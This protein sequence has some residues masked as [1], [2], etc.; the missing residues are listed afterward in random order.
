MQPTLTPQQERAVR[1]ELEERAD[2][3]TDEEI[4]GGT[5]TNDFF[6]DVQEKLLG[7]GTK[8]VVGPRGC[9]K[10]HMMRFA[11]LSCLE[12]RDRPFAIYV[13]FNRYYRL[14]PMLQLRTN[15]IR[16]F[17][18]WAL[19]NTV[20]AA[21]AAL[22]LFKA[23]VSEADDKNIGAASVDSL[24]ALVARLE[25]AAPLDEPM[26][27][28]SSKLTVR[29]VA[30][31]IE[32]VT[33]LAGRR[34]CV[35]LLDDAALTL[36]PDYLIEFFDIVRTIKT[37]AISPKA[38]IYPGTTE[39]GPRFHAHHEAEEVPVWLSP[40]NPGY[41][42][43]MREIAKKRFARLGDVS[44]DLAD[45]IQYAAFGIPRAYLAMLRRFVELSEGSTQQ[46]L[47]ATIDEHVT[48]RV[49]EFRTLGKKVP[50]FES[51]V[52]VGDAFFRRVVSDLSDANIAAAD[53]VHKQ[54][55]LGL[56]DE[57]GDPLRERMLSLLLEA[58]LLYEH[59]KVSHGEDRK[60]RRFTPHLAALM[61][62]RAF[63]GRQRGTSPKGIVEF[64]RRAQ[65]KHPLRRTFNTLLT[66]Q[67]RAKIKLSL[68]PCSSCNTARISEG[69]HF[70]HQCGAELLTESTFANYLSVP[71]VEVPGLTEWQK[72]KIP[73][74]T[75]LRTIGD[76]LAYQDPGS[77]LRKIPWVGKARANN[78]IR[79]V[80]AH[81]DEFFS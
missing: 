39:Y 2:Y 70:C 28:L 69:Q 43:M 65:A 71:L 38:S 18:V 45:Q 60:Y 49:A 76:L 24:E 78:M 29:A 26:E 23:D 72:E 25:T 15:A 68:P 55:W 10:T 79:L 67:D 5:A 31:F 27:A 63:S 42:G 41:E 53:S 44:P 34:R 52:D 19:A 64:L 80:H 57:P 37:A 33:A 58:G 7:R 61:Q 62:Q 30:D 1:D 16:L 77:E 20:L 22:S 46:A 47:N 81:V 35:L 40:D 75:G 17:Q 12:D 66:E 56:L 8:L 32:E 36:T 11:Q 48:A 51:L 3:I 50:K 54:L 74:F 4:K 21:T 13:S 59:P 73:L 9:G 14:E 6:D